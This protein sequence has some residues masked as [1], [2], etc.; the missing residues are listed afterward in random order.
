MEA[1]GRIN[2]YPSILLPAG[3]AGNLSGENVPL[4]AVQTSICGLEFYG[5][6]GTASKLHIH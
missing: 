4:F 3:G 5:V 2:I 6:G 1:A